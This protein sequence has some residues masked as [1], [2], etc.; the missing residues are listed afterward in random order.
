MGFVWVGARR[1]SGSPCVAS[2]VLCRR[3]SS[4][5]R[6]RNRAGRQQHRRQP[7]SP[8]PH[9]DG[10]YYALYTGVPRQEVEISRTEYE[11]LIKI[12]QRTLVRHSGAAE[13]R[14]QQHSCWS[15][16]SSGWRPA[17]SA[18]REEH[19]DSG[20]K[21]RDPL[22]GPRRPRR[23]NK[24]VG[25]KVVFT[26]VHLPSLNVTPPPASRSDEP[27]AGQ[28]GWPSGGVGRRRG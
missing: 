26:P 10:R 22:T 23:C 20:H 9:R 18:H 2:R 12:D 16:G 27:R 24:F 3:V 8:R 17:L 5:S 28:R 25:E 19:T 21:P 15:Q 14:G 7:A 13:R 4:P 6:R 11:A 1:C